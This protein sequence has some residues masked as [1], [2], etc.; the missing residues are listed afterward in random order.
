MTWQAL[1]ETAEMVASHIASSPGTGRD[2]DAGET[3]EQHASRKDG[4]YVKP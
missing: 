4:G 1:N 2:G 3:L